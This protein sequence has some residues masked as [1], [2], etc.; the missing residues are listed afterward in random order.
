[1]QDCKSMDTHLGTNW[2]KE[3]DFIGEVV[4]GTIFRLLVGYLMYLVNTMPDICF[5]VNQLS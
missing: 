3:D 4:D 1:M 2:R 5:V